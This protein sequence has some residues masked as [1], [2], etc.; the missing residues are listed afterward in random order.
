MQSQEDIEQFSNK[1]KKGKQSQVSE[2][3]MIFARCESLVLENGLDDAIIRCKAYLEAGADGIM[4]HSAKKDAKKI[5]DF[6]GYYSDFNG[7]KPLIVVPTSYDSIKESEL[8]TAGVNVVI[9]ANHLLRASYPAMT[10][11]AQSILENE[12][13]LESREICMSIKEILEIIPGTSP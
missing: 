2:D 11:V 7:G 3:C 4:I 1:I 13:S 5:L 8:S 9:Y 12:R 10:K 6:C